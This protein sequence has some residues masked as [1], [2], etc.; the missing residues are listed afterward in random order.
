MA[1]RSLTSYLL[2]SLAG[3]LA[4]LLLAGWWKSGGIPTPLQVPAGVNLSTAADMPGI[5]C[6]RLVMPAK[7]SASGVLTHDVVGELCSPGPLDGK[8]LQVLVSGAG[9]GPVYWDFPYQADTYSYVRAALRAGYATFNFYRL[10]IG[11]SDHPPGFLL[12]VDNQAYVLGQL[13]DSLRRRHDFSAVFVVGH[14]FGSVTAIALA[15]ARPENVDGI[16]LTGFAHNTNPGFITA[17]RTGVD[18]AAFKGPFVG[19]IVDPT[20]LISRPG[21][22]GSTF[23]TAENADPGVIDVDE[24]NRQTTAVGEVIS[25]SKY[26][27]PQSKALTV[28]VLLVLGEDDFVVCGGDL[29]CRDHARTIAHEQ[30]YFPVA[31]N[32]E[33]VMLEHTNHDASLH[34]G[35]PATSA[36]ILDWIA[37]R[38]S[39]LPASRHQSATPPP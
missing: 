29:D 35:A 12:N 36:L 25:S 3:L 11:E 8:V 31:R 34:R 22:R 26:F 10:G 20:Y 6:E 39:D 30:A 7:L 33:M 1:R 38:V 2:L 14:S 5:T 18:V 28:P 24:M 15:L 17:M 13:I 19:R 21:T 9:Y 27:G 4:V 37:R 16:V 32:F 23:Y